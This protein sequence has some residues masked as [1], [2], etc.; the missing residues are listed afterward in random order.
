MAVLCIIALVVLVVSFTVAG[1]HRTREFAVLRVIG[2][3][4][5]MLSRLVVTESVIVS[6][7]GALA[8]CAVAL[9]GMFAFGGAIEQALGL[10]FLAPA[11]LQVVLATLLVFAIALLAGPVASMFSARKLARVDAGQTLREE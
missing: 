7:F 11:V 4:R 1:R 6:A 9:A 5:S 8:G 2:A 3:T 10:P